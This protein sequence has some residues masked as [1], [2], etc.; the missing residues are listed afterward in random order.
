[1]NESTNAAT[2][3]LP[4][5]RPYCQECQ[6]DGSGNADSFNLAGNGEH[7]EPR[8]STYLSHVFFTSALCFC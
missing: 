2:P 5:I 7:C 3:E 6:K 4:G 8:R 1:M